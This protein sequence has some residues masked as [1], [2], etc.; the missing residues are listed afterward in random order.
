VLFASLALVAVVTS[1]T[2]G[3][4]ALGAELFFWGRLA[5][6]VIYLIGLPW[7]RTLAWALS[8][9]GLVLLFVQLM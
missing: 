3:M 9:V 8:M 2:N 5:Y 7:A 4:T 1:H 6:A